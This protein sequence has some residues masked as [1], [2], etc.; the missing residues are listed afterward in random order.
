MHGAE[1]CELP[2]LRHHEPVILV[3]STHVE[4]LLSTAPSAVAHTGMLRAVCPDAAG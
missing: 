3:N 1:K 4:D 2:P